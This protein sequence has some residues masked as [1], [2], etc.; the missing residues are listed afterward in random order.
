M[1]VAEVVN[2]NDIYIY[3]RIWIDGCPETS[4]VDIDTNILIQRIQEYARLKCLEAIKNVRHKAC[5]VLIEDCPRNGA[6][7]IIVDNAIRLVMNIPNQD[8]MPEL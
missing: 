6:N 5:D 8:V 3:D 1:T 7:N 2:S 4:L